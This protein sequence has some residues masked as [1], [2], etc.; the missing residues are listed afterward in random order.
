MRGHRTGSKNCILPPLFNM[1]GMLWYEALLGW[2]TRSRCADQRCYPYVHIR[3]AFRRGECMHHG[4]LGVWLLWY[5][6]GE[7]MKNSV[8]WKRTHP[9]GPFHWCQRPHV[10][11]KPRGRRKVV[12]P[13]LSTFWGYTPFC[14]PPFIVRQMYVFCSCFIIFG[15]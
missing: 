11:R 6:D 3:L 12:S 2:N 15:S 4:P 13:F 7:Y 9:A 14:H 1:R 5:S 8:S 10:H